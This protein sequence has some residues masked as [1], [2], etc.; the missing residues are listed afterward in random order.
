MNHSKIWKKNAAIVIE[1]H[2]FHT[3]M[4]L[5]AFRVDIT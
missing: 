3:N 5:L 4:N 1:I 2:Y